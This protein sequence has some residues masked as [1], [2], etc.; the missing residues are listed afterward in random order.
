M[1]VRRRLAALIVQKALDVVHADCLAVGRQ[2]GA[3]PVIYKIPP[4]LLA[5]CICD[6]MGGAEPCIPTQYN[7]RYGSENDAD[8]PYTLAG[9][10]VPL[11]KGGKRGKTDEK[12]G[13]EAC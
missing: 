11:K 6:P 2:M 8:P 4:Q 12:W 13:H 7:Q 5:I 9:Q 3:R 1:R 10:P